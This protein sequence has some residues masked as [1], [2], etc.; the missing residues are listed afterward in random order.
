MVDRLTTSAVSTLPA[1]DNVLVGRLA[2][3]SVM[4]T[5]FWLPIVNDWHSWSTGLVITLGEI[6]LIGFTLLAAPKTFQ[7]IRSSLSRTKMPHRW[8]LTGICWD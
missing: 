4:C 8:E 6:P 3:A 5:P 2:A 7:S 1:S